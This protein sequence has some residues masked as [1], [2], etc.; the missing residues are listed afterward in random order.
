MAL[1]YF[2]GSV[3]CISGDDQKGLLLQHEILTA[4]S[5]ERSAC[6]ERDKQCS[7]AKG[8]DV[9]R[10]RA[11]RS[12]KSREEIE[13]CER[14]CDMIGYTRERAKSWIYVDKSCGVLVL[15]DDQASM[16]SGDEALYFNDEKLFYSCCTHTVT[17]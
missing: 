7:S 11:K 17:N 10:G 1:C 5:V 4:K 15:Y 12:G 16:G 8:P 3:D 9:L 2:E 13:L 14:I 6:A